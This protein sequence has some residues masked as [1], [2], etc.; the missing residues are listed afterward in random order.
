[1]RH[2]FPLSGSWQ[3]VPVE[4]F[5]NG[6]YPF[7]DAQWE[8]QELPAHWQQH[9]LFARYAGKMVYRRQVSL[10][11]L[12]AAS[13]LPETNLPAAQQ[14]RV[15]LRFGGVFYW[16]RPFF[17]GADLG[18]HEGYFDAY[19]HDVTRWLA[20]DNTLIVEVDCPEERNN[21]SKRMVTGVFSHWDSMDSDTNPGG[22]WQPIDLIATGPVHVCEVL[23][24]TADIGER[25]A[26]IR[27]RAVLDAAN[28]TVVTLRWTIAPRNFAGA[29]QTL[30]EARQIAAGRHEIAGSFAIRDPQVWWTHDL[31]D[32]NCYTIMLDVSADGQVSDTHTTTFGIRQFA[33]NNWI[34]TLNG[35]RLFIKGTNYGPGDVRIATMTAEGF[36][37]DV[38]L[39]QQAHMNMLRVHAH[40][41][42]PA[43]YDVANE[44]GILIWQ[45]FPLQWAYQ[46]AIRPHAEQQARA[47]VRQ[48]YNHPSVVL[49]CMHNEAIYTSD[50][51]D[52]RLSVFLLIYVSVFVWNWNR[53]VL[54]TA[55]KRVAEAEDPTRPVVRSSGEYAVPLVRKGTDTHFYYGWYRI[56]GKLHQW[57]RL[58]R[59][60]PA[61]AR[62]VTEFGAQSFPNAESTR[63]MLGDDIRAIDWDT[64]ARRYQLQDDV[65]DH[66]LDWRNAASIEELVAM[67]QEYQI[68]VNRYYIDRLRLRKYRPT[69]GILPFMFHDPNPGVLWSVVDYWRVP[70][71]SYTALQ[72]A[73]N[74]QYIF[75]CLDEPSYA[76]GTPVDIPIYVVNDARRQIAATVIARVTGPGGAVL[77]QLERAITLEPDCETLTVER[78]RLT[79]PTMGQYT[80]D[81]ALRPASGVPVV[82]RYT[83]TVDRPMAAERMR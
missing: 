9:P 62:F 58:I 47:M 60:F 31:G 1:M 54:D 83:L 81:L 43:L 28:D 73:F 71:R 3:L 82:Q 4:R 6:L 57:E 53:S 76:V 72:L 52:E 44:S 17:N 66:W 35:V 65:M 42:H 24:D 14:R 41:S 51:K 38:R 8:D 23:L 22:I 69:G 32:P 5:R 79:P 11:A 26:R 18:L 80:V 19:E 70:K 63:R 45:D 49:W 13:L 55:L 46:R 25:A 7:P 27:Y 61:N 64:V 16:S 2:T 20:H 56:Y 21:T 68:E 30:E 34:A 39:A 48:L 67:T 77:A 12:G 78:L 10:A 33:M 74:P 15:W 40:I 50:T 36:A 29:V 37:E 59:R 75:T